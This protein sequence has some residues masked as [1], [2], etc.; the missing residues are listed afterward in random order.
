MGACIYFHENI[1]DTFVVQAKACEQVLRFA[2]EVDFW[3]V[4]VEGDSLIVIKK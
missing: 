4:S 2:Q 3:R 1:A